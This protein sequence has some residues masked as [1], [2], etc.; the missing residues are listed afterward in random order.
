MSP[1]ASSTAGS[2][3]LA[4]AYTS[5]GAPCS[6][7]VA[8]APDPLNVKVA[9]ASIIGNTLVSDAAASTTGFEPPAAVAVVVADVAAACELVVLELLLLLLP[10]PT[11]RIE[12]PTAA[13]TAAARL[14]EVALNNRIS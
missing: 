6:I 4:A 10:Q 3:G 5:A 13:R 12:V 2:F 9:F 7:S 8:S 11:A 1:F 14:A